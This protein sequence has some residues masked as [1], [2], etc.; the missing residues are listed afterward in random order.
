MVKLC[1]LDLFVVRLPESVPRRRTCYNTDSPTASAEH[2]ACTCLSFLTQLAHFSC[3]CW[4]FCGGPIRKELGVLTDLK[5]S[6][7]SYNQLAGKRRGRTISFLLSPSLVLPHHLL[8]PAHQ[9][10]DVLEARGPTF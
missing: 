7:P 1:S 5:E 4:V 6:Y 9:K 2:I 10:L 8:T 3:C